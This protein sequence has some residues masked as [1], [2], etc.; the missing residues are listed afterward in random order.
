MHKNTTSGTD[1]TTFIHQLKL[2]A[3]AAH[4]GFSRGVL[5][6]SQPIHSY[7]YIAMHAILRMVLA[8]SRLT[9]QLAI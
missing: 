9:M 6:G 5:Q 8:E 7:S 1:E 4:P 3:H 2:L